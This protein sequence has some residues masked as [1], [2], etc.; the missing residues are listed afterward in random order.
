M[1]GFLTLDLIQAYPRLFEKM[2]DEA[3][4]A[5]PLCNAGWRRILE[6]LC[7]RV[8]AALQEKETFKFVRIKTEFGVL[9]VDWDGDLSDDTK[10][11]V[12]NTIDPAVARS[13]C[14]RD[15]CGAEARRFNFLGW[16]LRPAPNTPSAIPNRQKPGREHI[17]KL[18]RVAGDP[19]MSYARCDRETVTEVPPSSLGPKEYCLI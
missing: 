7:I 16:L 14:T 6:R 18:R 13:A 9:R 3:K 2:P 5:Y 15:T 8:E 19:H 17:H 1:H 4:R 12:L 11:K 10:A